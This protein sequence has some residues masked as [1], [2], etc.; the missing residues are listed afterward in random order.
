LVSSVG[1]SGVANA[2]FTSSVCTR[3]KL[4][5][6]VAARKSNGTYT[7]IVFTEEAVR[8]IS[9]HAVN[10]P[11]VPMFMYFALHDTH[12][13]LEAPWQF[14]APYAAKFPTDTKRS[15]FS[16]MVGF[17]DEA[18]R[19][20]TEA[21]IAA[22]MWENTL[23]I[24]STDNG[25]PVTV[26]GSNHPLRGGKGSNWEGGTRVPTFVTG[27]VLPAGQIGKTHPGLIAISDWHATICDVAGVDP[28]AGEPN[29]PAALDGVSA[30]PWI[31]GATQHSSRKELVYDHRMF[32]NASSPRTECMVVDTKRV[33]KACVSGALQ[34]DGWKLVVGPEA[35]NGW[36][37]WFS[38]NVSVPLNKSSPA[39]VDKACLPGAPCLFNLN[40]S[41][42]EHHNVAAAN[43]EVVLSLL[44]RMK[45]LAEEY[46]PPVN[47][48]PLDLSGYCAAVALNGNFVGPWMARP[49]SEL[50]ISL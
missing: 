18:T 14:V 20:V 17:V 5:T 32:E 29:A 26:A 36:F 9:S 46:H 48:P 7:G 19:N 44:A 34:R 6:T 12:A 21:L 11:Q 37:G 22:D 30:W 13:P 23:F 2:G 35:Q 45:V 27:G 4:N 43:P 33:G 41:M 50:D 24:W 28:T 3:P 8:V 1:G 42:T 25:S 10:R 49:N 38:P 15:I 40:L 39:V 31:S 47:N 16:G